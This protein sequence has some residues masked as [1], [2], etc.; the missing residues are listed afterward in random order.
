[1]IGI[2]ITAERLQIKMLQF[3]F[4]GHTC[5]YFCFSLLSIA[6]LKYYGKKCNLRSKGLNLLTVCSPPL[7][8]QW[9][10]LRLDH[11]GM[12]L[13]GFLSITCSAC[14]LRKSRTTC[15]PLLL[16]AWTSHRIVRKGYSP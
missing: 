13:P 4:L 11:R 7:K 14:F 8:N 1:M 10:V 5:R 9:K 6:V 3:S 15:P 2:Y 12:L 16:G